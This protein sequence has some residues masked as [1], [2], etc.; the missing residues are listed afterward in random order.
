MG[1]T[2]TDGEI[3][4]TGSQSDDSQKKTAYLCLK[5]THNQILTDFG[6]PFFYLNKSNGIVRIKNKSTG[7]KKKKSTA[8]TTCG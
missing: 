2:D 5:M 8:T 7:S 6:T 1:Q 4:P 3:N